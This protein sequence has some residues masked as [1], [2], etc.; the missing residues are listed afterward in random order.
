MNKRLFKR[1]YPSP[2]A[3]DNSQSGGEEMKRIKKMV[4]DLSKA[5]PGYSVNF[6]INIRN[7]SEP[8]FYFNIMNGLDDV[9]YTSFHK[10]LK[11]LTDAVN[12]L[13]EGKHE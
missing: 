5:Y 3:Q 7:Y 8:E 13:L 11:E 10:T 2:H 6:S 12:K 4:D 1:R 9:K